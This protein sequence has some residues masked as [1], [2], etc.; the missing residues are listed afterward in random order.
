MANY[1]YSVKKYLVFL[2]GGPDG[3]PGAANAAATILITLSG[4]SGNAKSYLRFFPE[5][6]SLPNNSMSGS[7]SGDP[8]FYLSYQY[9]QLANAI[10]LLRN[11]SPINFFFR[12]DTMTGYINTGQEKVGEGE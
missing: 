11:E 6:A 9:D 7:S 1:S 2:Y 10:D 3:N 12:D 5:G 4:S 8:I